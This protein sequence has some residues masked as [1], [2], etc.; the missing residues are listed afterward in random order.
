MLWENMEKYEKVWE[1][2]GKYGK[3]WEGIVIY[4]KLSKAWKYMD[5]YR[6]V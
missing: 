1:G 3:L 5:K 4:G 2:M 6:I